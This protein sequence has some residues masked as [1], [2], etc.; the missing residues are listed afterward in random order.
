[1]VGKSEGKKPLRR[2]WHRWKDNFE[3]WVESCELDSCGSG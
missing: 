2:P 3:V 1:M